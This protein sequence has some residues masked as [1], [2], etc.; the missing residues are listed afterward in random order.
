M[1]A[2]L[3]PRNGYGFEVTFQCKPIGKS[4][5]SI[6]QLKL[7]GPGE[8]NGN[9]ADDVPVRGKAHGYKSEKFG[10]TD[11]D[12]TGEANYTPKGPGFFLRPISTEGIKFKELNIGEGP[13]L[14]TD[15]KGHDLKMS[16]KELQKK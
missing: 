15:D 6:E 4:G 9:M 13:S 2:A 1:F 12:V 7:S 3:I 14:A 10:P 11:I 16:C 5:V 8:I